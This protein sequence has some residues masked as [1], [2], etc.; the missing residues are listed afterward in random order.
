[1]LEHFPVIGRLF[2]FARNL[3][4]RLMLTVPF[5]HAHVVPRKRT[6]LT[7]EDLVLVWVDV[8]PSRR[9]SRFDSVSVVGA[10][11]LYAKQKSSDDGGVVYSPNWERGAVDSMQ[12]GMTIPPAAFCDRPIS[13]LFFIQLS[14]PANKAMIK[15]HSP[16]FL[17][18]ITCEVDLSESLKAPLVQRLR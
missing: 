4:E 2:A 7:D 10:K 17:M 5:A 11:M 8:F 16:Y 14:K 9:Q 18:S 6:D 12:I 1:M 3:K 13:L 15:L